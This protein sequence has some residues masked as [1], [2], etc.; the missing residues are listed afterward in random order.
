MKILGRLKI[1]NDHEHKTFY[2]VY[3]IIVLHIY[4]L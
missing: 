4:K 3:A 1:I 2:P